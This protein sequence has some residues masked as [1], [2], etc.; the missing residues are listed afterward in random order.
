M[1]YTNFLEIPKT[2]SQ[3]RL[4]LTQTPVNEGNELFYRNEFHYYKV[5][6]PTLCSHGPRAFWMII[7][8][9]GV[10]LYQQAKEKSKVLL[11]N[12][13]KDYYPL[14]SRLTIMISNG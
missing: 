1:N 4:N 7:K 14:T 11:G 6:L 9:L 13:E 3:G 8:I 10:A 5:E 12:L 2:V